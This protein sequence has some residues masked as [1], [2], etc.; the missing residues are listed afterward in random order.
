MQE[1]KAQ[2]DKIINEKTEHR[3]ELMK[4]KRKEKEKEKIG[5]T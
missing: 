3:L 4:G 5:K 1:N 2:E